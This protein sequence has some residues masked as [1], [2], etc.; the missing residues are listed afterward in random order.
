[1]IRATRREIE[2]S[3]RAHR[4][5]SVACAN[6]P[7]KLLLFY[8]IECGLK[9]VLMRSRCA[10]NYLELP[11]SHRI[12]HDIREGLKLAYA[13]ARLKVR[14]VGSMHDSDPQET[15]LPVDLHQAFRYG[16][17]VVD[18]AAVTEELKAVMQWLNEKLG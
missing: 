9:A 1:M 6:R 13:P 8:G 7:E 15:I 17:H 11:E 16:V 4:D 10:E 3:Y 5:R 2:R 12:G 14:S 18:E